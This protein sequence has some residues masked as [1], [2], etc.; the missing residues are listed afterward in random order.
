MP[1]SAPL[2]F[3]RWAQALDTRWARKRRPHV[4]SV[5]IDARTPMNLAIVDPV[6]RAMKHDRRVK[7]WLMSSTD[8]RI[9]RQIRRDADP[10][11][12][13]TTPTRAAFQRFDAYL[14]ADFLW[15]AL[16]RGVPRVQM[17]HGVAGKY[18]HI[19]DRPNHSVAGWRQ[20]WFIN[21]RR[22]S[23]FITCGAISAG[24]ETARLIGMP[25]LDGL[26]DGSFQRDQVLE[27]LGIDPERR[28]VLYVPT[29]S[30]YTSLNLMG[31]ELIRQLVRAGHAVIVK[32]HDRSLDTGYAHSGG[33]DWPA[34]L[35][36][37]LRAGG[38][39]LVRDFD[40]TPYLAAADV[41][42]TDHSSA[43]FEYLLLDRPLIRVH[44]PR[45]IEKTQ[46]APEYVDLLS[47]A[48]TTVHDATGAAAAVETALSEPAAKSVERRAV[49]A[50]LFHRPG[51]ATARAVHE[52]YGL[53]ELEPPRALARAGNRVSPV[54][55]S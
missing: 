52:L 18:A 30:P 14:A 12:G 32:L 3:A 20:F 49:A 5:V 24:S 40:A 6:Y 34:R 27:S 19:Y 51:T 8:S 16:P 9:G 54:A 37:I 43:G 11:I 17:F 46:I 47:C 1:E 41:A 21:Q 10:G 48:A 50:N 22:L 4:R 7:F 55:I 28:A 38:G 29:W 15:P 45:L 44:V 36:P 2:R 35:E 33:V 23:N 25:K 53:L 26:V 31:E 42:I 13:F 39:C